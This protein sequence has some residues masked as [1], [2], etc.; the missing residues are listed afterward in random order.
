MVFGCSRRRTSAAEGEKISL[1][2]KLTLIF[3][4]IGAS[5]HFVGGKRNPDPA[6]ARFS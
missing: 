5:F 4:I 2:D 3:R 1:L 6:V